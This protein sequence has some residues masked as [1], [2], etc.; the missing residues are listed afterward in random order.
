MGLNEKI[1]S[2]NKIAGEKPFQRQAPL[3]RQR[4]KDALG[5]PRPSKDHSHAAL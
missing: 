2:S 3:M 4:G 1:T 5:S